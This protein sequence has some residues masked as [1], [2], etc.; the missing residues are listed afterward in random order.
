VNGVYKLVEID[1]V[2]TM[3][4]ST[5]KS[6]YPGR[7]QIFR[8]YHQGQLQVEQLGLIT[9]TPADAQP[10][11]QL[12][13]QQGDRLHPPE[14]LATIALRTA[15]AVASLPAGVRRIENP[16]SLTPTISPTL[17]ELTEQTQRTIHK[18]T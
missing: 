8:G 10:L 15:A 13:M 11:M 2:P 14:S 17:Q 5:G 18:V 1:G 3:K 16:T 7:K 6:T 4:G 12:V 9:D